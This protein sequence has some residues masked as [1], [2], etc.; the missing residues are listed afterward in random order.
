MADIRAAS[1][2]DEEAL[3]ALDRATWSWLSSPVPAPPGEATFFGPERPPHEVLVAEVDGEV[4]GYVRVAPATPL[5]STRHVQMIRGIA[6]D[7]VH[8]GRGI[9]RALVDAAIAKARGDGARRLTLRV[10]APNDVARRLY[11]S[12]GFEVEGVLREEFFLDGRYVDDLLMALR[13]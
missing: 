2:A 7:P 12:A 13:L 6:V 1:A 10:F 8:R 9:G 11:A 3:L 5:E 4:A